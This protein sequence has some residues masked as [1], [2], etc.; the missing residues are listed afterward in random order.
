MAQGVGVAL[1]GFGLQAGGF[2]SAASSQ[3]DTAVKT[4]SNL[5]FYP[6]LI[7]LVICIILLCFY[8]LDEKEVEKI[9]IEKSQTS[10][11]EEL[12]EH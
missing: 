8:K 4:I 5:Y 10:D 3:P 6:W 1:I 2:V 12:P 9:R 11:T 7:G